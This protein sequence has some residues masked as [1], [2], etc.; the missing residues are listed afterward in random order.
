MTSAVGLRRRLRELQ[1]VADE[2][3]EILDLALLVVVREDHRVALA[4]EAL[5]LGLELLVGELG[6]AAV[7]RRRAGACP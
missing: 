4:L 6:A 3:G 5:D 2:V 7:A 1:R